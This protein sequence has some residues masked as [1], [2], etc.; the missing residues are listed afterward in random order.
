[1]G[2]HHVAISTRDL[3]ATDRFYRE[4]MGFALAKVVTG[5][6]PEGG[7]SKHVFYDTGGGG[8]LAVWELHDPSLPADWSP[9][10]S[11]GLGLPIWANHLAFEAR[12][13]AGLEAARRRW[14]AFGSDVAEIDHGFCL[15]LYTRDPNGI[16]VE[17]CLSTRELDA[18]D[19][20]EA[21]RRLC[22][23]SP[24]LDPTPATRVHR[25]RDFE[26]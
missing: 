12:D 23:P 22:D 3:A 9:A 13:R 6:T 4:A 11:S 16:L 25:A 24:E 8:L 2:F 21:A 26:G 17:W 18:R 19:R 1:M 5:K 10:I 15:S 20:E 14:L 7:W